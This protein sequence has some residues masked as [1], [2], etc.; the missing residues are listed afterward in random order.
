MMPLQRVLERLSS[1]E[2]QG[3]GYR[4]RCPCPDHGKGRGDRNPSL[5]LKEGDDGRALINCFAGCNNLDIV[6][7]LGLKM[8]DLFERH[9]STKGVKANP[10]ENLR[11]V[12]RSGQCTL[13]EYSEHKR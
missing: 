2:P 3:D 11:Y 7:A 12:D 4:A 13:P 9:S 5:S 8:A 10:S 1:V 6:Y